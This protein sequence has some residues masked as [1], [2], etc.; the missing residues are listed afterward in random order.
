M[1]SL[2]K[3]SQRAGRLIESKADRRS[4]YAAY[5]GRP[6][7]RRRC[8]IVHSMVLTYLP[9]GAN[10]YGLRDGEFDMIGLV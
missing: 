7:S 4:T 10:D 2:D 8:A 9:D 6:N 5:V 1:P 3:R